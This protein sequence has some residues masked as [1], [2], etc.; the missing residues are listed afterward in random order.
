[1][2]VSRF[3]VQYRYL[4]IGLLITSILMLVI[5]TAADARRARRTVQGAA[6]GA[7][8]GAIVNGG[9]GAR[10]GAVAGGIIGAVR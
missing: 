3:S 5:A 4:I 2:F 9:R 1:M 8:V 7:G 6:I 10:R